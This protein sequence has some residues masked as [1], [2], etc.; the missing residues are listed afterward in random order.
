MRARAH[1]LV[2]LKK[3]TYMELFVAVFE[4][5]SFVEAIDDSLIFVDYLDVNLKKDTLC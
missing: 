1:G 4:M 3:G 5:K 2:R